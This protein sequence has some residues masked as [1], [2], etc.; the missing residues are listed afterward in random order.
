MSVSRRNTKRAL[1]TTDKRSFYLVGNDVFLGL[2][3]SSKQSYIYKTNRTLVSTPSI[4][5]Y[6]N[7]SKAII[8]Y[9]N[10]KNEDD[11][12][13]VNSFFN[14]C[15]SGITFEIS[16]ATYV[17]DGASINANISGT[18][19]FES[20]E[21]GKI[22]K[23][24][25]ISTTKIS[26]KKDAYLPKFFTGTPQLSKAG[27][28]SATQQKQNIIKNTLSSGLYSFNRLGVQI[29]D[30][31]EFSGTENNNGKKFKVLDLFI[32]VDGYETMEVDQT[33]VNEN[34]I[35]EPILTNLYFEGNPKTQVADK[36][37]TYGTCLL[38]YT[39]NSSVCSSCQ[40][41]FQCAERAKVTKATTYL[42]SPNKTCDDAEV[43]TY[44]SVLSQRTS[45]VLAG[46]TF[47]NI[48]TI[49]GA[50]LPTENIEVTITRPKVTYK[51]ETIKIQPVN[52][53]NAI[54]KDGSPIT[55]IDTEKNTTLKI[56][57]SDP[58]LNGYS[59]AISTTNPK[60]KITEISSTVIKNGKP[61]SAGSYISVQTGTTA[62][63][64]YLTTTDRNLVVT[65]TV[66]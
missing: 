26:T 21:Q 12:S 20:F 5:F 47:N 6:N 15:T 23:A 46:I 65:I 11:I 8:D 55:N 58:T 27:G 60:T 53:S 10:S 1:S 49:T 17:E 4:V 16:N 48:T 36:E 63:T 52:G 64:L 66:K 30:Y 56:I 3:F 57:L 13:F 25:V 32:D 29:G 44:R 40:N 35:G 41:G 2:V 50:T 42:Y 24:N 14:S 22:I 61:G 28:V 43:N 62:K 18:Y 33:V 59:F 51:S 39:V 38:S 9:S 19:S 45:A 37:K 7:Q 54:I 34:L 31:I